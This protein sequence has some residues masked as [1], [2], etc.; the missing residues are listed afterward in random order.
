V[1]YSHNKVG[2]SST[3]TSSSISI[4]RMTASMDC[5][6]YFDNGASGSMAPFT[7]SAF[8]MRSISHARIASKSLAMSYSQFFPEPIPN[9][10]ANDGF[11]SGNESREETPKEGIAVGYAAPQQYRCCT[12]VQPFS[13]HDAS[14]AAQWWRRIK[15]SDL[16][17]YVC[18]SWRLDMR[19]KVV[20]KLFRILAAALLSVAIST[21]AIA[22]NLVNVPGPYLSGHPNSPYG[23]QNFQY[24]CTNATPTSGTCAPVVY[25][26]NANPNGQTTPNF[27]APVAVATGQLSTDPCWLG[28]SI[29][30]PIVKTTSTFFV[31]ANT[32][33][34]QLIAPPA[35]GLLYAYI[36]AIDVAVYGAD[37]FSLIQGLGALC[38]RGTNPSPSAVVGS[39]TSGQGIPMAASSPPW[40]RGNG[41]AYVIRSSTAGYGLCIQH[42]GTTAMSVTISAVQM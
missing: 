26:L 3:P 12:A 33:V 39:M 2:G 15:R 18:L 27:S 34:T 30:S 13:F 17:A 35:G 9:I 16:F 25:I 40:S 8:E 21:V 28:G 37:N 41:G 22:Q 23:L 10:A 38:A 19:N 20:E 1:L 31:P 11:P 5:K 7:L 29:G 36:C 14:A 4:A 24:N 32:A 42:S 6:P